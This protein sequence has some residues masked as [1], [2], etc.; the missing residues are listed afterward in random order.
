LDVGG[1]GTTA[2]EVLSGMLADYATQS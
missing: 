2:D 1:G